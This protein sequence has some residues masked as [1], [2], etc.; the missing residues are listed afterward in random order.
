MTIGNQTGIL[1]NDPGILSP[2]KLYSKVKRGVYWMYQWVVEHLLK[3][4]FPVLAKM[5]QD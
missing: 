1:R 5:R 3:N 4:F 2:I